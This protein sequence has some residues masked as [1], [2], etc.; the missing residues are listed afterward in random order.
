V[1]APESVRTPDQGL[2]TLSTGAGKWLLI[3]LAAIAVGAV[4]LPVGANLVVDAAVKM[5]AELGV[6]DAIV[7][8][9]RAPVRPR[10]HPRSH[11][12]PSSC[13]SSLL[14]ISPTVP[15]ASCVQARTG[16]AF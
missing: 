12:V 5:A 1:S 16:R 10:E 9:R 4:G 13:R 7:A 6:D 3:W 11:D 8:G 14:A 15:S 2:A